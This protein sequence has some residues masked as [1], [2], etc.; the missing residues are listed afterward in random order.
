MRSSTKYLKI[1]FNYLFAILTVAIILFVLPK[2]LSFFW[3]FVAAAVIAA[4]AVTVAI[5]SQ[6][7]MTERIERR[8]ICAVSCIC[9]RIIRT[10]GWST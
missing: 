10:V 4:I 6:I 8:T 3:P 1:L 2:A 5:I 7:M 9:E